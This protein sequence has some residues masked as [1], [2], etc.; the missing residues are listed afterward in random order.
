MY[1][2][3]NRIII[4]CQ[5]AFFLEDSTVN[6]RDELRKVGLYEI[7]KDK[8]ILANWGFHVGNIGNE[9]PGQSPL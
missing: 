3:Y 6:C 1:D 7:S 4:K 9:S 2:Q 8:G 5:D